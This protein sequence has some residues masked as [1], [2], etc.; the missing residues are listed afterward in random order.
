MFDR[1]DLKWADNE[2]R[3]ISDHLLATLERDG[4]RPSLWRIRLPDGHLTE[5]VDQDQARA[6]AVSLALESLALTGLASKPGRP[7]L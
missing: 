2:L 7:A 5:A 3:L 6:A 1:Y 4:A